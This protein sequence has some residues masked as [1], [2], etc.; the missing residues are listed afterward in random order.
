MNV[1]L[2]GNRVCADV[3]KGRGDTE[4][5][6]RGP[7]GDGL[8]WW[9]RTEAPRA[10]GKEGFFPCIFAGSTALP[11]LR[12]SKIPFVLTTQFDGCLLVALGN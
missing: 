3:T 2:F 10:G 5:Q 1:I 8:G 9:G 4:A 6:G 7:G 11:G 12:A